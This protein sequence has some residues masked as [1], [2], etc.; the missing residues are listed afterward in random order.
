MISEIVQE[1]A[2]LTSE[3]KKGVDAL[4][5]AETNLAQAEA[6][7]DKAESQALLS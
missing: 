6:D 5:S 7:L 1:I 2:E 3:N 4:Y